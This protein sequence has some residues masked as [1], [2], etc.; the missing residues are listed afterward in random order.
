MG[1]KKLSVFLGCVLLSWPLLL[2]LLPDSTKKE[3]NYVASK[4]SILYHLPTCKKT[5]R[6]QKQNGVTFASAEE[7]VKAGYKPCGLC[8]PPG[9]EI[10]QDKEIL[11]IPVPTN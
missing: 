1:K 9:K 7:A 10:R 11:K 5:K 3:C 4:F 2:P 8:L 6:I